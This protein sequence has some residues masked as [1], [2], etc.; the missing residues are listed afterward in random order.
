MGWNCH[1]YGCFAFICLFHAVYS[2]LLLLAVV[3]RVYL[4]FSISRI[5]VLIGF[6]TRFMFIHL[7]YTASTFI[8]YIHTFFF[9]V[10][11]QAWLEQLRSHQA[12][13][14]SAETSFSPQE[15][16]TSLA[17]VR[18]QSPSENT[19]MMVVSLDTHELTQRCDIV[20]SRLAECTSDSTQEMPSCP[21]TS[22]WTWWG[23]RFSRDRQLDNTSS[24]PANLQG[25]QQQVYTIVQQHNSTNSHQPLRLI[26]SGTA[27]TGKS[28]VSDFSF[29]I[30][31]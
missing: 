7:I 8:F 6:C 25:K 23:D 3:F 31:S 17:N 14:I 28:T 22:C 20:L 24:P 16:L 13:R 12:R 19:S 30:R 21:W 11:E 5:Y 18:S 27:G 10:T 2:C 1:W 15:Q 4:Y 29:S 9:V 26:V